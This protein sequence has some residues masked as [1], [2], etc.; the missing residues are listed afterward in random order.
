MSAGALSEEGALAMEEHVALTPE[1]AHEAAAEAV[2]SSREKL[3]IEL[4]YSIESLE[5]L[6]R[7]LNEVHVSGRKSQEMGGAVLV[8]GCYLGE[9]IL[10]KLGGKWLRAEDAGYAAV[11][12]FPIVLRLSEDL[13]CNPLGKVAKRIDN[14]SG[15]N[16]PFFFR[17]LSGGALGRWLDDRFEASAAE[18]SPPD[19]NWPTR[20]DD[21]GK[22]APLLG[23]MASSSG[24]EGLQIIYLVRAT[25]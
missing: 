1:N 3:G 15:D 7:I 16:L 25:A 22:V 9:V 4:D 17:T 21:S 20:P 24:P 13:S 23:L 11:T 2:Q 12:G 10:R 5:T 14:G 6:D 19:I 18:P 8:F